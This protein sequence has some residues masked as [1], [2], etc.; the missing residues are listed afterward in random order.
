LKGIIDTGFIDFGFLVSGLYSFTGKDFSFFG[1]NSY[2]VVYLQ[3]ALR[4]I[5]RWGWGPG[6]RGNENQKLKG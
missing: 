1:G 5:S 6:C 4:A 3:V 2:R